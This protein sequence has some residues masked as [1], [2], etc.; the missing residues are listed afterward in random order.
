MVVI[1]NLD[2][3]A[4]GLGSDP[5][6]SRLLNGAM[7]GARRSATLTQRLLAF[8]RRQELQSRATD[9]LR[10]IEEMKGLIERSLGPLVRINIE[11]VGSMPAVTV[12]PTQLE[13]ALLNLAVNA[14]D[15]M[16]V[17]AGF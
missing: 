10:L 5:R 6:L 1:G 7:E 2:L 9:V 17:R 4:K 12:D 15:A 11:A 3:L 16:R 14:R 8:A 13:M